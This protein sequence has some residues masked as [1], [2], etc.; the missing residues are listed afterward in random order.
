MPRRGRPAGLT[1]LR[2]PGTAGT[3]PS[4]PPP[5]PPCP[6]LPCRR[7]N[8]RRDTRGCSK[9]Q[10]GTRN[11]LW[12]TH[13]QPSPAPP[14]P[15]LSSSLSIC[16]SATKRRRAGPA[17]CRAEGTPP[18]EPPALSSGTRYCL[19]PVAGRGQRLAGERPLA[20]LWS[21][22]PTFLGTE[23]EAESSAP[24]GAAGG[25]GWRPGSPHS[26]PASCRGQIDPVR[27]DGRHPRAPGDAGGCAGPP[28]GREPLAGT[29]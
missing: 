15:F 1:A 7:C 3:L 10:R 19:L 16:K 11:R 13:V 25:Q 4:P 28:R 23:R 8:A 18:L 22:N 26:P 6:A 17:R 21:P 12:E 20:R 14:S 27:A 5:P 29:V 9:I 2:A 24:R